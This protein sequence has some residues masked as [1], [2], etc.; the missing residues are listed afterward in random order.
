[1]RGRYEGLFDSNPGIEIIKDHIKVDKT[2]YQTSVAGI[3]AVGDVIGP[4]WLAHV[5]SEEAIACVERIA[6]HE[7]TPI[8]YES[9]PGC[10]YCQPQVASIGL[11]EQGCKDNGLIAGQDYTVGKFPFQASGKAQAAGHTQGFVKIIAG[12]PYGEI[13]GAHMIGQNVTE[14]ITELGLARRLEA[15]A[16]E[17]IATMHAHPT[18]SEAVHEAALGSQGRMIHF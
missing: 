18:L 3:Y 4:P 9:I 10:T 5:A 14:L 11:T 6:G 2:T 1:M 17:V 8:D 15:T 12:K 7:P 13:L 16:E